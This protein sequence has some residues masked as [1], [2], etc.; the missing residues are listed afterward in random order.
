MMG[1]I[2]PAVLLAQWQA[3]Q[4]QNLPQTAVPIVNN[5]INPVL[6]QYQQAAGLTQ[7]VAQQTTVSGEFLTQPQID[8]LTNFI[9]SANNLSVAAEN[10]VSFLESEYSKLRDFS[11]KQ[12]N[13]IERFLHD[14]EFTLEYIR[15]AWVMES[16]DNELAN[17]IATVYME[18]DRLFPRNQQQQPPI[19]N[20]AYTGGNVRMDAQIVDTAAPTPYVSIP[21][22][23]NGNA[24]VDPGS[25]TVE[26]YFA[27]RNN[28]N[29]REAVL[30]AYRDPTALYA[31]MYR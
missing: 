10:Y 13:L 14:R 20:P 28:G 12:H 3:L 31:A 24:S 15:G 9:Q 22:L 21:A 4:A 1:N 11:N 18:I 6:Q 8:A 5:P 30:A 29:M 16:I 17:A 19:Q 23:P 7:Q 2:D 26:Q 25:I 27:A